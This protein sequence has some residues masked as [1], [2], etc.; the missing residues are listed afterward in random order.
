MGHSAGA[1]GATALAGRA[2][3]SITANAPF[4][5]KDPLWLAY[6][7]LGLAA[8]AAVSLTGC[9]FFRDDINRIRA[10]PERARDRAAPTW[11]P[12]R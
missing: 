9:Q 7:S 10:A 11:P 3:I 6:S 12:A 5:S 4:V 1:Q 2:P 8:A